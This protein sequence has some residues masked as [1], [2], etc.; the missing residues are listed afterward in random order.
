MKK[1]FCWGYEKKKKKEQTLECFYDERKLEI[2]AFEMTS[3]SSFLLRKQNGTRSESSDVTFGK[4]GNA[5]NKRQ[6]FQRISF[7]SYL[8]EFHLPKTMFKFLQLS[9]LRL[10]CAYIEKRLNGGADFGI[11]IFAKNKCLK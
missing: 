10:R 4:P 3:F 8:R 6:S 11:D 5:S 9:Q 7:D 2:N 1:G